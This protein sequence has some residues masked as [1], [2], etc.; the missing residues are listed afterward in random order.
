MSITNIQNKELLWN[1]LL[2]N[3]VFNNIPENNFHNVK[4]IF[5]DTINLCLIEKNINPNIILSKE[6]IIQ[7]NKFI[8][9]NINNKI[10]NF[11]NN[12]L[13]STQSSLYNNEVFNLTLNEDLDN[14]LLFNEENFNN[15]NPNLNNKIGADRFN[16]ST[17]VQLKNL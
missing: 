1:V 5:E 8:L 2:N 13:K 11:K 14:N 17:R 10:L 12:L 4:S 3:N 6:N 15:F 7:I 9:S 16:N